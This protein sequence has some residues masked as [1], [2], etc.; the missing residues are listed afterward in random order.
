M[1]FILNS[2]PA[3]GHPFTPLQIKTASRDVVATGTVI[4]ADN[5]NLE[6]Q[7][8][9]IQIILTFDTDGGEP[10]FG[11]ASAIGSTLTL[12]LFNFNN[13]MGSGTNAPIEIG[14]LH[15]RKLLLSFAI[16]ALTPDSVKTVH[17]TFMVGDPA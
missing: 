10:R 13:P 11:S 6:F 8:A 7:V 9:D 5:K 17:Y 16:H 14:K 4:T 15:G 12:P 1:S 2:G 3:A